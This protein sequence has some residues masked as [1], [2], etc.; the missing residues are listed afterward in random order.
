MLRVAAATPV[1]HRIYPTLKEETNEIN[2]VVGN[3]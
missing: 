1:T 3:W 2:S